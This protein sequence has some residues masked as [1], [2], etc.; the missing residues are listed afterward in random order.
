M[1]RNKILVWFRLLLFYLLV[2]LA[3]GVGMGVVAPAIFGIDLS[4]LS[5]YSN[6]ATVLALC[7]GIFFATLIVFLFRKFI[8]RKTIGSLG[9][10][11]KNRGRSLLTGFCMGGFV[12]I[13]VFILLLILGGY[14]VDGYV[15][16]ISTVII[17]LLMACLVAWMEELEFRAYPIENLRMFSNWVPIIATSVIFTITHYARAFDNPGIYNPA[18]YVSIFIFAIITGLAY[19]KT[20]SIYLP[21]GFHIGFNFLSEVLLGGG[22]IIKGDILFSGLQVE[23]LHWIAFGLSLFMLVNVLRRTEK[24]E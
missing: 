2:S 23:V 15:F 9:L 13:V 8:D 16:P 4:E 5:A 6:E 12:P 22:Q 21:L 20:Q 11:D 18:I 24:S 10:I 1:E 19:L 17:A 3:Q 14:R 7:V